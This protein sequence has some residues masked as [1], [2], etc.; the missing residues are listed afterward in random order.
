MLKACLFLM[1]TLF[2][3]FSYSAVTYKNSIV[4]IENNIDNEYFITPKTT[5]P[6]FSGANVFTKYSATNQLSLGY[7]GYGGSIPLYN[8]FDIWLENS[9]IKMPF[10]GN[11][12][13]RT[14]KDC[15]ADGVQRPQQM[16][17]D[18]MYRAYMNTHGGEAGIPRG[19]FSDSFYQ[20]IRQLPI[21]AVELFNYFSCYTKKDYNPSL[22]ETC[23]S[24]KGTVYEQSFAITKEGHIKLKSTNA[25]QEI[26]VDSEGNAILGLG[27]K[28]CDL[29]KD[30]VICKMV[31]YNFSGSAFSSMY[32]SMKVDTATLKFTPAPSDIY[33]S[34]A[35]VAPLYYYSSTTSVPL[36][37]KIGDGG[38]YVHFKK[39]FLKKLIQRNVDLSKSQDL[40]TFSFTNTAVPQSGFYEFTPSNTIII[41]PRDYGVSI[42]SK[43]LVNKPYREGKVG[44]KAPPLIFDYIITTS[45]FRQADKITASVEGPQTTIRG[46][47][48]CLF[49]SKDKKINVPFSAYLSYTSQNGQKISAR[50]A[51]NNAPV[52]LKDALWA[53]TTWPEPYQSEGSFY[54]TDLQ[55]SFPMDEGVSLFSL[56]GEDW[57]GVVEASGYVNVFAEWTGPD[58][59]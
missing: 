38:V 27:S 55:L 2:S 51:C 59:H 23:R 52:D 32:L 9:P 54:R 11:R 34:S 8:Y 36:L 18:G 26:F 40:F 29:G 16:L 49:T 25:L 42:V 57:L 15:P 41:K 14:Y 21:G 31:D 33:L 10:I 39:S 12:C 24:V 48:Y 37:M 28:F 45:A 46:Q 4:F 1:L 3:T 47:P 56:E 7:M 19:I 20:Y 30:E 50:S 6:R 5:D 35:G 58:V 43:D 53:Q 44:N 22:G 13:W 17:N